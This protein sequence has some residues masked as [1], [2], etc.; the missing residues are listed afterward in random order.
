MTSIQDA[1][2]L[3]SSRRSSAPQPRAN[4]DDPR[5]RRRHRHLDAAQRHPAHQR[6]GLDRGVP[7]PPRLARQR[8]RQPGVLARR[9]DPQHRGQGHRQ[10]LAQPRVRAR[11]GRGPPRGDLHIHD[12]DMFSGYC[13]G[14]SLR[15]LLAEGFNGVGGKVE[16]S[17]AKHFSLGRRPDRQLPRHAPERVGRRAGVLQ[18]RHLHGAVHPPR[19][20]ELHAGAP[21]RPGAHLQ[22]Q[23]AVPLGHPDAVHQPH[24]RLGLPGGP[25]RPGAR[26]RAA[27][28]WTSPTATS[29]PRW[30]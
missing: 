30:T 9:A 29:R 13:A 15:T 26:D 22:P 16:A 17:P 12:L 23:R 11:G 4:V 7:L 10:L 5:P 27:G 21:G 28:R 19:G 14:W 8:Q 24:V 6:R 18:L 1:T 2:D 20:P 25:P 3:T